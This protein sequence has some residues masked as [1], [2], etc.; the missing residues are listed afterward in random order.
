[1]K[2]LVLIVLVLLLVGCQPQNNTDDKSQLNIDEQLQQ[3]AVRFAVEYFGNVEG[4]DLSN[5][6][7]LKCYREKEGEDFPLEFRAFENDKDVFDFMFMHSDEPMVGGRAQ[8]YNGGYISYVP[9][10]AEDFKVEAG[11][12]EFNDDFYFEKIDAS[13]LNDQYQVTKVEEH[14][15]ALVNACHIMLEGMEIEHGST[16]SIYEHLH[17]MNLRVSPEYKVISNERKTYDYPV[18]VNGVFGFV[19]SVSPDY[20]PMG[21]YPITEDDEWVKLIRSDTRFVIV[22]A[23]TM[24]FYREMVVT[25]QTDLKDVVPVLISKCEK[26]IKDVMLESFSL[27]KII[28]FPFEY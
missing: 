19:V 22:S 7:V 4:Y 2:K 3:W 15:D 1:M 27:K 11:S 28:E 24:P 25:R 8:E 6:Y 17:Y 18:E 23:G 21:A 10:A 26:E 12:V 20:E 14:Y 16:I 9:F 5:N 13:D